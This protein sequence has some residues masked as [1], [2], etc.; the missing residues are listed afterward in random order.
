VCDYIAIPSLFVRRTFLERGVPQKKLIHVPY[1]VDLS[2]FRQIPKT[3][4]VF[5]VVFAGGMTFRKGV[6]YLLAAF[7]ELR[8]P[9]SE[10]LLIG[11]FNDEMEGF[12]KKYK[13]SFKWVGAV[14]QRELYR[15]YSQGSV[16]V[17]PSIEEGL[18]MVQPQAMACGLPVICTTNTGGE[19][20]IRDGIDGFVMP[21][22]D[23]EVLKEKL[24]YLYEHRDVCRAMGESAKQRVSTGFSWDDYGAKIVAE[25]ER[26]LAI[27]K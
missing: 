17:L 22:R 14:P 2:S 23:I 8:L 18:A 11:G 4:D 12:F 6:H 15:Y 9:N 26:V 16:F 5:R 1:G 10:L 3:D 19:D 25:Y 24:S 21:I 27:K 20:I 13:G 7:S